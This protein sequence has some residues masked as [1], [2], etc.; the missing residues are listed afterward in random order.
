M[1]EKEDIIDTVL[2][3]LNNIEEPVYLDDMQL[4]ELQAN[5]NYLEDVLDNAM[6]TVKKETNRRNDDWIN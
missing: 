2:F 4:A 5:L 3:V 6:F 1:N